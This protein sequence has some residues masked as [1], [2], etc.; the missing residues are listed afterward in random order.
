MTTD[1]SPMST[2]KITIGDISSKHLPCK[3]FYHLVLPQ[4]T[5]CFVELQGLCKAPANNNSTC[6]SVSI[7]GP[8]THVWC[9]RLFKLT[10]MWLLK[11][12]APAA[13]LTY[14]DKWPVTCI[15]PLTL[16]HSVSLASVTREMQMR[17]RT[18]RF[19]SFVNHVLLI[20]I[21]LFP[22]L[23]LSLCIFKE[24]LFRREVS[25]TFP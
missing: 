22:N 14:G 13:L 5:K 4:T 15:V 10:R 3:T 9:S 7:S 21:S 1:E 11:P 23:T 25:R 8:L 24:Q 20:S 19:L 18:P 6:F 12:S 17:Q 16:P 2:N